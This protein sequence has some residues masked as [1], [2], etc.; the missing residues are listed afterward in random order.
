MD[1][2]VVHMYILYIYNGILLSHKKWNNAICSNMDGTRN[3]DTKW[4]YTMK[5]KHH[6]MSLTCGVFIKD[7]NE[8]IYRTETDS[9]ILK[10]LMVNEEDRWGGGRDG[11]R[12][13]DWHMQ[14]EVH[15]T[16]SHQGPAV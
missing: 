11:L 12:V 16:I 4:T 2:D 5:D 6:M 14:T 7:T 13:W 9:Q 8:L 10:Y 3:Y 15:R 1:K